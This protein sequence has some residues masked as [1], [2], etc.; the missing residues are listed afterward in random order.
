VGLILL[1][2]ACPEEERAVDSDAATVQDAGADGPAQVDT[3]SDPA[4]VQDAGG[5]GPAQVD[6][7]PDAQ[8]C[9]TPTQNVPDVNTSAKG[10]ACAHEFEDVCVMN[11]AGQRVALLCWDGRWQVGL[12]GACGPFD[13]RPDWPIPAD[14]QQGAD[15]SACA[16]PPPN[17]PVCPQAPCYDHPEKPGCGEVCGL[18]HCYSCNANGTWT[19]TVVDCIRG[20][21]ATP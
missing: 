6:T 15:A 20:D 13:A 18:G 17:Y 7:Q 21:G 1:V 10:C 14:A 12:D 3:Q 2:G 16:P 5:D 4:T 11:P 8:G 9:Y 19:M